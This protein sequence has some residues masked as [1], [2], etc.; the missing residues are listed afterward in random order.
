MLILNSIS[1][2]LVFAV[3]WFGIAVSPRNKQ[4]VLYQ[5]TPPKWFPDG[6][7]WLWPHTLIPQHIYIA[8]QLISKQ[9]HFLLVNWTSLQTTQ[10]LHSLWIQSTVIH[11][12]SY[13]GWDHPSLSLNGGISIS[14]VR[15]ISL[16]QGRIQYDIYCCCLES[17]MTLMWLVMIYF[18]PSKWLAVW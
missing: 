7:M 9:K 13:A 4:S 15:S 5:K 12:H 1:H 10:S 3:D 11:V 17:L 16:A 18:W 8:L 14:L 6:K 2:P